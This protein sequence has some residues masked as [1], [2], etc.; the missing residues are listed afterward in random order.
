[1]ELCGISQ[2]WAGWLC[3]GDQPAH[4]WAVFA[5][6]KVAG[7]T[8]VWDAVWGPSSMQGQRSACMLGLPTQMPCGKRHGS[9]RS[10]APA[11]RLLWHEDKRQAP[12]TPS[13]LSTAGLHG[14][15]GCVQ[16]EPEIPDCLARCG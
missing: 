13:F 3:K 1:M 4:V 11:T 15:W 12:H 16:Q 8:R 2:G 14:Q 6:A 7:T 5:V 9:K 10:R